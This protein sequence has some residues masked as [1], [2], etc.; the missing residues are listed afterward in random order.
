[1]NAGLAFFLVIFI[2]YSLFSILIHLF[3]HKL[4]VATIVASLL[5][6]TLIGITI[7]RLS[8]DITQEELLFFITMTLPFIIVIELGISFAFMIK[9]D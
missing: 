2:C 7:Y 4:G 3:I 9:R 5:G 8:A 6:I 1:M